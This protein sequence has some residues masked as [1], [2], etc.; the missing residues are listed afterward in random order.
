MECAEDGDEENRKKDLFSYV[1][2]GGRKVKKEWK[3]TG[4]NKVKAR[5]Q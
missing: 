3:K 1:G 4:E 2:K 5:R